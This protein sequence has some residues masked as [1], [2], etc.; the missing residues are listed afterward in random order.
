MSLSDCRR[1]TP[2]QLES[3]VPHIIIEYSANIAG[4]HDIDHLVEAVHRAALEHGLPAVDALRT[5][6]AERQHYRV[7]DGDPDHAFVAIIARVGPGREPE[8]KHSFLTTLIDTAEQTLA[9]ESDVLAIAFSVELQEIDAAF[10]INRNHVR[11]RLT[12]QET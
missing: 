3:P 12:A 6:A 8:V 10:R 4:H 11:A 9:A 7:A 1:C 5:R 2:P